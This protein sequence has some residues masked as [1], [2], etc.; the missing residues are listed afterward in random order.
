MHYQL[1]HCPIRVLCG[2]IVS[3]DVRP[4]QPAMLYPGGGPGGVLAHLDGDR[5]SWMPVGRRTVNGPWQGVLA[6]EECERRLQTA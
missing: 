4:R 3:G 5:W 6:I 1:L 2:E